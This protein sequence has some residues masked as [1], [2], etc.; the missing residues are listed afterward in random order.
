[1]LQQLLAQA[2]HRVAAAEKE[3]A[4]AA[5]EAVVGPRFQIQT[6]NAISK[7]GLSKFGPEFM[8]TGDAGPLPDGVDA[9]PHA[10]LL[11]SHKLQPD[12]VAPSVRAIARCGAGQSVS[13]SLPTPTT[14]HRLTR[15]RP[16]PDKGWSCR[17]VMKVM[18]GAPVCAQARTTSRSR[19]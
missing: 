12:E 18:L 4:A 17:H 14:E 5:V 6:F 8:L 19:R 13:Q 15:S 1:M 2:Q 9:E 3:K 7:V 16:S 10:I 11:R